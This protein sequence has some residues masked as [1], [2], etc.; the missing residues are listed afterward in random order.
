[1]G[2]NKA[3]VKIFSE[4]FAQQMSS[5]S[6]FSQVFFSPKANKKAAGLPPHSP[7]GN[8]PPRMAG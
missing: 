1:M 3:G 4:D 7:L 6:G 2:A 5:L 8:S